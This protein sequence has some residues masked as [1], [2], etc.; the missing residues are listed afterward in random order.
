MATTPEWPKRE[1]VLAA[2][3]PQLEAVRRDAATVEAQLSPLCLA[4]RERALTDAERAL[5]AELLAAVRRLTDELR[6]LEA[7]IPTP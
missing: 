5:M 1:E 6:D 7:R 4:E 2:L 3:V